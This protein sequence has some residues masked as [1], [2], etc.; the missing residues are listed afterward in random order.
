[1]AWFLKAAFT[2]RLNRKRAC[3]AW[4]TTDTGIMT[5][6][7]YRTI[8]ADHWVFDGTGLRNGDE[9]EAAVCTNILPG[10][11]SGYETDKMSPHSPANTVLLAKGLNPDDGGAEMTCYE[12]DKGGAAFA[13]GSITWPASLLVDEAVSRITANVIRRFLS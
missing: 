11:A 5:G 9:L 6:A 8:R 4:S 10:G 13:A 7:P 2:G 12:L 3:S 1:M